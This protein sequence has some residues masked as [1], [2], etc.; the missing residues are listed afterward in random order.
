MRPSARLPPHLQRRAMVLIAA[1]FSLGGFMLSAI[2]AQMVPLLG[3]LGMGG[4]AVL[5]S[6]LFGPSQVFIRFG[7]M[8]AGQERHPIVATLVCVALFPVAAAVL[9]VTAPS[10]AGAAAFAV[11]LGFGSGLKSIVQGTLPLALF[12]RFGYGER[13]GR[14]AAVRLVLS[15]AA[16]FALAWLIDVTGPTVALSVMAALGLLGLAALAEVARLCRHQTETPPP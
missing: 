10:V 7:N 3:A 5:V 6:A 16:P 14:L 1:G 12:G 2:L 8:L 11:I 15:A 4:S 9:L 13:L